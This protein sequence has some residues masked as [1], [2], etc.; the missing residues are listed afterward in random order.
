LIQST[1]QSYFD[2]DPTGQNHR[3]AVLVPTL[4]VV[5]VVQVIQRWIHFTVATPARQVFYTVLDRE[6]KYKAKSL[7][8][9]VI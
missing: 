3:A 7:I 6:E 2:P 9:V 8:D 1:C 4:T 5:L